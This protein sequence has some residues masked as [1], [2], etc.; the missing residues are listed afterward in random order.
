MPSHSHSGSTTIDGV[1][2]HEV[3]LWVGGGGNLR[4][5]GSRD[6]SGQIG[7]YPTQSA[8]S[9]SHNVTTTDTGGDQAHENRPQFYA[10]AFI[11]KL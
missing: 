1:H 9:H 11:Y 7:T 6:D 4:T 5:T 3:E 10:L 8:G 2:S